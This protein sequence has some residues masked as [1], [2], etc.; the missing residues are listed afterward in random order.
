[1]AL[2]QGRTPS[3]LTK[4]A[5]PLTSRLLVGV[6]PQASPAKARCMQQPPDGTGVQMKGYMHFT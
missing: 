3:A 6:N 1:M 4:E 2:L 5:V